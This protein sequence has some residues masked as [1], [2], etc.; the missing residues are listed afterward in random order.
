MS[1]LKDIETAVEH[2]SEQDL[3]RFRSWFAEFDGDAWDRKLDADIEA[4]RLDRLADEA[5]REH[6]EGRTTDL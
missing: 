1:T 3:T 4:G 6:R 2:L 5:I